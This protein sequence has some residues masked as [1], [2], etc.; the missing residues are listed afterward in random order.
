MSCQACGHDDHTPGPCPACA[1]ANTT[2]WQQ[3]RIVGGDG[4]Q[5]AHGQIDMATGVETR[6]CVMCRR[7]DNVGPKRVAE[8]LMARGLEAASDGTFVTPIAKDFPGRKSLRLDPRNFGF[9]KR[10]MI[11][12]D[13]MSS[14]P[15]WAPTRTEAEFK[16]RMRRR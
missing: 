16:Q 6:P 4:D 13:S 7:W 5:A 10:D 3:I 14:C 15:A 9:C 2:C 12:T 8:H 1:A 11:L